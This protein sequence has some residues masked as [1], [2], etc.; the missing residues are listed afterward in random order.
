MV[1]LRLAHLI[2]DISSV[3]PA[4]SFEAVNAA[5]VW[6]SGN[7]GGGIGIA[8]LDSGVKKYKE[9]EKDSHDKKTGLPEGWD[10]V[11]R[12]KGGR[13]DKNG[14]GTLVAS[15]VSNQKRNAQG[16][17]FWR[18]ARFERYPHSGAQRR[19]LRHL[20][21]G[22]RGHPVGYRSSGRIQHSGHEPLAQR[23]GPFPLLGRPA[24]SSGYARLA[25]GHCGRGRGR[26]FRTCPH[27]HRRTRQQPLR[28]HGRRLD[29][30][31]HAD[32]LVR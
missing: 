16:Q 17:V 3:D 29:R 13:N 8:V 26:Q 12:K 5:P 10:S 22:D 9:L 14:H 6:D 11:K 1:N 21:S 23:S 24:E 25:G 4:Q 30:R 15:I 27:E 32:R 31:L 20:R 19:R 28:H 7:T 2:G 18:C